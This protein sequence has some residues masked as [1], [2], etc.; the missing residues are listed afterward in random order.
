MAVN[1][2]RRPSPTEPAPTLHNGTADPAATDPREAQVTPLWWTAAATAGALAGLGA[3]H[4][5]RGSLPDPSQARALT[6][7]PLVV[8]ASLV[9]LVVA[10]PGWWSLPAALCYAAGGSWLATI[11]AYTA[12]LPDRVLALVAATVV[13]VTILNAALTRQGPALGWALAGA[14]AAGLLMWLVHLVTRSGVGFG[15]A[16]LT[17][18]TGWT[19]ALDSPG[20]IPWVLLLALIL[21]GLSLQLTPTRRTALGPWLVAATLISLVAG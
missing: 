5:V 13:A 12:T 10:R 20:R 15:D 18:L 4:H 14:V 6:W 21:T 8:A 16:K 3:A 11:D 1:H 2:N 9:A 19:L 7:L 17:A